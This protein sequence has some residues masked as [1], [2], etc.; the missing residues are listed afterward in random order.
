MD[1]FLVSMAIQINRYGHFPG[2]PKQIYLKQI[3]LLSQPQRFNESVLLNKLQIIVL[4]KK[5]SLN[6]METL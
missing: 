4:I 6:V 3:Y 5:M 2:V 1:I